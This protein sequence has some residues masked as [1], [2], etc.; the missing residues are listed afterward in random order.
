M[1]SGK[2]YNASLQ[3]LRRLIVL[4]LLESCL[5]ADNFEGTPIYNLDRNAIFATLDSVL[6]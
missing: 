3:L 6:S 2:K 5:R 1:R 4:S